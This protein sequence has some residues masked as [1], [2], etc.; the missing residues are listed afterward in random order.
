MSGLCVNCS[1]KRL[2]ASPSTQRVKKAVCWIQLDQLW[3]PS[4]AVCQETSKVYHM[5][6]CNKIHIICYN[7]LW[8]MLQATKLPFSACLI[9][10][11][12]NE[13]VNLLET[14]FPDSFC[15]SCKCNLFINTTCTKVQK[16]ISLGKEC[17]T[18]HSI[19]I[20]SEVCIKQNTS[21]PFWSLAITWT[22]YSPCN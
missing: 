16:Y 2:Q 18:C 8:V 17:K 1:R 6:P 14:Q 12:L 9:L 11:Y 10:M 3:Y 15:T 4:E 20:Q 5:L 19:N 21:S 13:G 7:S 22:S